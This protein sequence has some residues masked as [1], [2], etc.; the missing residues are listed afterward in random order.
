[1][2]FA[3]PDVCSDQQIRQLCHR[4]APHD[5]EHILGEPS[6]GTECIWFSQGPIATERCGQPRRRLP[7]T[8]LVVRASARGGSTLASCWKHGG[9][10]HRLLFFQGRLPI[11]RWG[12]RICG[13]ERGPSRCKLSFESASLYL[14]IR[15]LGFGC[16]HAVCLL[17]GP[18]SGRSLRRGPR[19][20]TRVVGSL[21]L[22]DPRHGF[23]FKN[24]TLLVGPSTGS[25]L[26]PIF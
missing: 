21:R 8:R 18:S 20:A 14:Q 16:C 24:K 26:P 22:S 5:D 25:C 7:K 15:Y 2:A 19:Q 1:M 6:A 11:R 10:N 12:L 17:S 9:Q 3:I 4:R 13:G 23:D